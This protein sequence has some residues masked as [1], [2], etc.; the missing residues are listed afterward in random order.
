MAKLQR[1]A[2]GQVSD[3][4]LSSKVEN[5]CLPF[6]SDEL[7]GGKKIKLNRQQDIFYFFSVSYKVA[8]VLPPH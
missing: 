8:P 4:Q 1:G 7:V 5:S 2:K 6:G 3:C